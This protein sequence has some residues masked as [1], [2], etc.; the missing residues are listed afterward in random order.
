MQCRCTTDTAP[1]AHLRP[2]PH[3]PLTAAGTHSHAPPTPTHTTH[4]HTPVRD[5]CAGT[6]RP[7]P[8]PAATQVSP[9]CMALMAGAIAHNTCASKRRLAGTRASHAPHTVVP[10]DGRSGRAA[11]ARGDQVC[12]GTRCVGVV[13]VK[14]QAHRRPAAC[15]ACH[16]THSEW[17][18]RAHGVGRGSWHRRYRQDAAASRQ[19]VEQPGQPQQQQ[20]QQQQP[21]VLQLQGCRR[22]VLQLP[23]P[24][25]S[26]AAPGERAGAAWRSDATRGPH[27]SSAVCQTLFWRCAHHPVHDL[28]RHPPDGAAVQRA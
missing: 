19:A 5:A 12:V 11:G 22:M 2:S 4:A 23:L 25:A 9:A 17:R 6:A 1:H 3:T 8:A 28:C 14:G 13:C 10:Q 24:V 27:H 16:A 21:G 26:A 15:R 20:Q 7:R 18:R